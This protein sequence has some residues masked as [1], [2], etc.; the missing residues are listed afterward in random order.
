MLSGL[1][2][3]G[4]LAGS[5]SRTYPDADDSNLACWCGPPRPNGLARHQLA[6]SPPERVSASGAYRAGNQFALVQQVVD[7]VDVAAG[8][9]WQDRIEAE[10]TNIRA[11]WRW[12]LDAGRWT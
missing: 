11:A 3:T 5:G 8:Q 9:R 1:S 4:T 12:A 7:P 2:Q 6:Q 10:Y